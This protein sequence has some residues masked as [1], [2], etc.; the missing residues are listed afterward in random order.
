MFARGLVAVVTLAAIVGGCGHGGNGS[1]A[2][3]SCAGTQAMSTT[4]IYGTS[5]PAKTLAFTFDDG[6][7]ARTTELSA[8]LAGQGIRAAFF[9]NGK[10]LGD[11]TAVLGQL[12]ADGHVVANHTQ[13][14]TSLTGRS[15]GGMPLTTQQVIDEVTQTDTLIAPFVPANRFLFRAPYG[16]FD[17]QSAAAIEGSPMEKYVGPIN[18]DIG[19]H[20]GPAQAADW[21]C[22]ISGADSTVLTPQQCG[23]RYV[24]EIDSVGRGVVLMHDPYFIADDPAH[25]GTVDMVKYVVPILKAKGYTFVRIDAVPDIAALLPPLVRAG[26]DASTAALAHVAAHHPA[27][28]SRATPAADDAGA[29]PAAPCPPVLG[30]V[31][32]P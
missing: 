30:S 1:S 25:G 20:M 23:D 13:T 15:T 27:A 24:A 32:R 12:V 2:D 17:A 16:D 3:R 11:G 8:Y 19:D 14:H 9:V 7:G 10:M 5:L 18:W 6:P 22:W 21:D 26:P 4:N 29:S 28:T 31:T